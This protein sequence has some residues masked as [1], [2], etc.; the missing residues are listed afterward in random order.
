MKD[1]L[2]ILAVD[3]IE[4]NLLMIRHMLDSLGDVDFMEARNGREA[5]DILEKRH[6][7]D[8]VLLDLE[9]RKSTPLNS[10]HT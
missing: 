10:S 9:D 5:L 4:M 2:A 7:V 8:V 1:T 3:D 6:D